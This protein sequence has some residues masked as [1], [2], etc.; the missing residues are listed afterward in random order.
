M[1]FLSLEQS[2]FSDIFS[3]FALQIRTPFNFLLMNM[4]VAEFII[5]VI[6]VPIDFVASYKHGWTLGYPMCVFTGFVL[7]TAGR[8]KVKNH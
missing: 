4:V 7:T 3:L 6:G 5:A 1:T 2:S 8:P